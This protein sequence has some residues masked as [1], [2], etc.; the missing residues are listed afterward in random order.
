MRYLALVVVAAAAVALS[1][2]DNSSSSPSEPSTTPQLANVASVIVAGTPPA[3]GSTSQFTAIA[4]GAD[5][6]SVPVTSQATWSSS[7]TSIATVSS[8]GVVKAV[9][10][11][12][13]EIAATYSKKRGALAF[14]VV[15]PPRFTVNGTIRDAASGGS[16]PAATMTVKDSAGV[17]KTATTDSTGRYSIA[18]VPGGAVEMTATAANYVAATRSTTLFGDLTIDFRLSRAA[19]C[20]LIGFDNLQAHGAAFTSYNPAAPCCSNPVGLD[21]IQVAF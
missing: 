1:G 12:S 17:T 21:N 11:G 3:V 2:C 14:S 7:D 9:A 6:T 5:G 15:L 4:V 8:G 20:P 13:V 19:V 18:G 16:L 10:V